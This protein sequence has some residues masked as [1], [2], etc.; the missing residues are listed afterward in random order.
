MIS[1]KV[2][3]LQK[4]QVLVPSLG[5]DISRGL[6]TGPVRNKRPHA[7]FHLLILTALERE[8]S[9]PYIPQ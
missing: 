1:H 9:L 6:R 8:R 4:G 3:D 2:K 7:Q 5:L